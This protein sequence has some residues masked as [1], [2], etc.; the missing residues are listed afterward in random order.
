PPR[1]AGSIVALGWFAVVL[2]A[3]IAADDP[4]AV[5]RTAGQAA[6]V[7]VTAAAIGVAVARR[8]RFDRLEIA[9]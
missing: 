8:D 5:F 3:R 1:Q 7:A 2:V 9:S 4:L 6:A